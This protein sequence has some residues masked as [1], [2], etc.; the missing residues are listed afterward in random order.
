MFLDLFTRQT[1]L[2]TDSTHIIIHTTSHANN[3]ALTSPTGLDCAV[4]MMFSA[5][6]KRVSIACWF[7]MLDVST[8]F[9]ASSSPSPPVIAKAMAMKGT[10]AIVQKKLNATA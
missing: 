5:K 2:N 8:S 3:I 7:A 6:P 9:R 1:L 4:F 10:A